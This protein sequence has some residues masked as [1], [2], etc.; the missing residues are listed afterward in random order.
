MAQNLSKQAAQMK[1][2]TTFKDGPHGNWDFI[3]KCIIFL[4]TY[5]KQSKVYIVCNLVFFPKSCY[6]LITNKEITVCKNF[7]W[8][9]FQGLK[10]RNRSKK[11]K[12]QTYRSRIRVV[13]EETVEK[14]LEFLQQNHARIVNKS[15]TRVSEMAKQKRSCREKQVGKNEVSLMKEKM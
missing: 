13:Q 7:R 3:I 10:Y 4:F 5:G 15:L 9:H 6:I 2:E 14:S 1:T 8:S 11:I 12:G